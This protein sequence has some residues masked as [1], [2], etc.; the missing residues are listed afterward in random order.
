MAGTGRIALSTLSA[1]AALVLVACGDSVTLP[2]APSSSPLTTGS[3]NQHV[4]QTGDAMVTIDPA[5]VMFKVDNSRSLVVTFRL[6]S[7]AAE[8]QSVEVR[9]SLYDGGGQVIGDATG[10]AVDVAPGAVV[11]FQLNG[12][13]PDGS[14]ASVTFEAHA[15]A[16][17]TP[18][19]TPTPAPQ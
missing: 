5:S 6:T 17:P 14:I 11:D 4:T 12:N 2:E 10:G 13:Y 3:V 1:T 15:Q 16:S 7:T 9:A 19:G 18:I 8:P